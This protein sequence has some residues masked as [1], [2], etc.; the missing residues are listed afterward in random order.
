MTLKQYKAKRKFSRTSEPRGKVKKFGLSR[1]VV[2]KHQAR[3]LHYDFRLEMEG[4]L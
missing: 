2:H 1:F 4:V 3:N